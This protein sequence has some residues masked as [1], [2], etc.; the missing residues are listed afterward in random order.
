VTVLTV[1]SCNGRRDYVKCRTWIPMMARSG[2]AE[3]RVNA[4]RAGWTFFGDDD[5]CPQCTAEQEEYRR[6]VGGEVDDDAAG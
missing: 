2:E 5:F 4:A 6:K 3:A 1:V